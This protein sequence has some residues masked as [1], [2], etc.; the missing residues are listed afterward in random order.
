M[1]TLPEKPGIYKHIQADGAILYI[2]KAK[3]IKKRVSSYFNKTHKSGKT[4]MLVKRISDVKY[5]VVENDFDALLL[6]NSLIKKHQPKYNIQLKD[7]K[8][9]PWIK[10][11]NER[12]P[13]VLSTRHVKKDSGKYYGPYASVKMMNTVLELI[14]QLYPIRTCK[15][16]LSE[17]N[18]SSGKYKECLEYHL[19][20][21][22]APCVGWQDEKEYSADI[23]NIRTIIAGNISAILL[24]LE[25]RMVLASTN[26]NYEEAQL[27]KDIITLL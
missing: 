24:G 23:E 7:D 17:E 16:S 3:N 12:F 13:R 20:N 5:I 25:E 27:L 6:E 10:K 4:R 19:G 15:Y 26:L 8:T 11:T 21:C 14:R 22:K 1:K 2:G 9:Y 18:V